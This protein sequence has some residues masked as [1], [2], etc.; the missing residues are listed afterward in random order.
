MIDDRRRLDDMPDVLSMQDVAELLGVS[1]NTVRRWIR[2]G[3]IA[4][5]DLTGDR[6]LVPK[7]Q[8]LELIER[9]GRK[10]RQCGEAP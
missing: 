6:R 1:L 3:E 8:I 7:T 9:A 5:L 2:Y 10:R 4:T